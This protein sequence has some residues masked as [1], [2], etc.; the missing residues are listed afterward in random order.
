MP[1]FSMN[2]NGLYIAGGAGALTQI[3]AVAADSTTVA[4]PTPRAGDLILV[5]AYRTNAY[6][7]G[8]TVP[9]GYT[10]D[11]TTQTPDRTALNCTLASKISDGTETSIGTWTYASQVAAIV[12]R[13]TDAVAPIGVMSPWSNTT[14]PLNFQQAQPTSTDSSSWVVACACDT[15]A[16][17]VGSSAPPGLTV[18]AT[19]SSG[20]CALLSTGAPIAAFNG[21]SVS[22]ANLADYITVGVE[23]RAAGATLRPEPTVVSANLLWSEDF[24]YTTDAALDAAYYSLQNV[25]NSAFAHADPTG[26][27]NGSGAM[28]IDWIPNSPL[29]ACTDEDVVVE[30][31][32]TNSTEVYFQ[33]W[34]KYTAGFMFDWRG[35]GGPCNGASKK[36]WLSPAPSPGVRGNLWCENHH[37]QFYADQNHYGVNGEFHNGV[38]LGNMNVGPEFTPEM[39][40]DGN[41]HRFTLH[42][43]AQ[44]ASGVYDGLF[45]GWIDGVQHWYWPNFDSN[46][47]SYYV[48]QTPSVFNTGVPQ[49]QS[50]WFSVIR[51]WHG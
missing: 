23:I 48:V 33:W 1:R 36:M 29:S 46:A 2:G 6:E 14:S 50:E 21:T 42:Q 17:T 35:T 30:K 25:G 9:S 44:S 11:L 32:Y 24:P 15:T 34:C 51:C 31:S 8:P 3:S 10:V 49:S 20:K 39:L 37:F 13:G 26:G 27:Y 18:Q 16:T 38:T 12:M 22:V 7:T 4:I 45:E 47:L 40:G 41:W 43:K 5:W 28:R 19:T